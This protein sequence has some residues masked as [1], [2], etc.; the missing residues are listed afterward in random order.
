MAY[1][2]PS[3]PAA[4]AGCIRGVRYSFIMK[5]IFWHYNSCKSQL[6]DEVV[7]EKY[8]SLETEVI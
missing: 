1:S 2:T 8:I 5:Y 3:L 6:Y 7:F 4:L